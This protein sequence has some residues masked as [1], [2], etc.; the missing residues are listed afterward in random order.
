MQFKPIAAVITALTLAVMLTT[1]V[2]AQEFSES[3]L[4]AAKRAIAAT[5]STDRMDG[6]LPTI[7]QN[8]KAELI[9]TRPDME[10]K[11][12][13]I[14]DNAAI[15][16]AGRR[17][18]LENEVARMFAGAFSEE[19]LTTIADFYE[20]DTGEKFLRE[21]PILIREM[22]RASQVW[23]NGVRRDLAAAVREKMQAEG[24]Q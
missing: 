2:S 21:S 24:L 22:N 7:A 18:D 10:N 14:V 6:I 12:T 13:E 16:L 23:G 11:I 20:S 9:R 15:E 8:A 17:A 3:H 5:E 4:K 1:N 19:E